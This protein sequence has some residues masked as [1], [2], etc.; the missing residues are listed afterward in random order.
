LTF[1]NPTNRTDPLCV[2]SLGHPGSS[3]WGS[4]V[5]LSAAFDVYT[6]DQNSSWVTTCGTSFATPHVSAT[7]V[8]VR[9]ANPSWQNTQ[10]A[11]QLTFTARDLGSQGYDEMFGYGLVQSDLA[12]GFYSPTISASIDAFS[13]PKLSW[14]AVPMA[15]RYRIYHRVT[16]TLA[17]NWVLWDSTT[18]TSY[19]DSPTKVT[20]FYGYSSVPG[21]DT[22]A[23][24]YYVTAVSAS[25][26]ESSWSQ[27]ETYI[28]NGTPPFSPIRKP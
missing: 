5:D 22:T 27:Y 9:A 10:V 28:P 26:R 4:H 23:V 2:D 20:S 3:N 13:K 24:G 7:A 17:P 16:P 12:V 6:T 8:L 1:A 25:G 18:A 11:E 15:N 21:G 19:T 14:P